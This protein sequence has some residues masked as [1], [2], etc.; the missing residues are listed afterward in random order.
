MLYIFHHVTGGLEMF[1]GG[2]GFLSL[3]F[4]L[5]KIFFIHIVLGHSFN[6]IIILNYGKIL[7]TFLFKKGIAIL[8]GGNWR[9][10]MLQVQYLPFTAGVL[11]SDFYNAITKCMTRNSDYSLYRYLLWDVVQWHSRK[12]INQVKRE[13]S[14]FWF[15]TFIMFCKVQLYYISR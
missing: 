5:A 11:L 2:E 6:Y 4:T 13:S 7:I 12:W 15:A 8:R 10:E 9:W 14:S 3:W 1:S